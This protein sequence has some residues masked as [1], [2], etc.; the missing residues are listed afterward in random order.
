LEIKIDNLF[1][2]YVLYIYRGL[3]K[4][5]R[6]RVNALF[7]IERFNLVVCK[8]LK[9]S[10]PK[11]KERKT[12]MSFIV[13]EKKKYKFWPFLFFLYPS[14]IDLFLQLDHLMLC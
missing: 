8:Q 2:F 13:Y 12:S 3:E 5:T 10:M 7:H 11:M 6:H 9:G 14:V 4:I 1:L